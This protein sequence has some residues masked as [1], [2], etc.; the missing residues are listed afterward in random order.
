MKLGNYIFIFFVFISSISFSQPFF[1]NIDSLFI[2]N[3]DA[4]NKRD[5]LYYTS[6]LNQSEIFKGKNNLTKQDSL[7]ALKPFYEAF[8][9]VIASMQEMVLSSDFAIAYSSYE[10]M[11]NKMDLSKANGKIRLKVSLILNDTFLVRMPF[12]IMG[13]NG[14]YSIEIPMMAMFIEEKE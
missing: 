11:Y 1:S 3:V 14:L 13:N 12:V 4:L 9:A 6:L 5:A 2:K 10:C 7:V 8:S